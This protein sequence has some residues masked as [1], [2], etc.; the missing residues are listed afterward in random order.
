MTTAER[1][2]PRR[3]GPR[4]RGGSR[5][6]RVRLLLVL[7]ALL[8]VVCAVVGWVTVIAMQ[9]FLVGQLDTQLSSAGGRA[10]HVAPPGSGPG[11]G[12]APGQSGTQFLLAPGQSVGT[13]GARVTGG[14]V[15][16]ADI[17]GNNG[18]LAPV[19][20]GRVAVLASVRPGGRPRTVTIAGLGEFR[21]AGL[22]V[23]G[24]DVLITGLPLGDVQRTVHQIVVVELVVA[25]AGLVLATVAG[26]LIIRRT[27][28]PL[29]RVADTA[30][31]VSELPLSHGEVAITERID[32]RQA[33]DR[34]EVGQVAGAVNRLLDHVDAALTIRQDSE[35][36]VRR[37]V[38]DASHELRT[39]LTAIRGYAELTRPMRAQAPAQMNYALERVESEAERMSTMVEDLLML[40]RLDAGRE[41]AHE[42]VDLTHLLLDVVSDAVASGPGHHYE[43]KLP[44]EPFTVTGD[45]DRLH[46]VFANLLANTRVHTP[47]GTRVVVM[48]SSSEP[49][50][51]VVTVLDDGPGIAADMLPTIFERFARGAES[52]HRDAGSTGLGLAI[53]RAIVASHHGTVQVMSRP[54]QTAFNVRLPRSGPTPG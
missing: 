20:A 53:V 32:A 1:T 19:A 11:G 47:P 10:V 27:L 8:A 30:V 46:Q 41:L 5:S 50:T 18:K 23:D 35:M 39:P 17:L 42:P 48:L 16:V 31:R 40:A 13:L 38:A 33:A 36:K 26:A 22:M 12:S 52:R 37:F 24:G 7:V 43:L 3:P 2:V 4:L 21:V 6:L 15:T 9:H 25:A 54:G 45:V 29:R 49:G 28:R 44:A 14:K 51:A 34:T